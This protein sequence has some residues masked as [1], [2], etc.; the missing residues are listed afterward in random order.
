MLKRLKVAYIPMSPAKICFSKMLCTLYTTTCHKNILSRTKNP[1][2]HERNPR[3]RG[4]AFTK[5]SYKKVLDSGKL[6]N[7]EC[8]ICQIKFFMWYDQQHIRVIS[9]NPT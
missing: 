6:S 7:I 4:D 8:K 1:T 5:C 9:N 2:K 3:S